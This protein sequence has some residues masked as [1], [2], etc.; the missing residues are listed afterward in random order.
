MD[1][2]TLPELLNS[3]WEDYVDTNLPAQHIFNLFQSREGKI[4]NDHVAFRTYNHPKV[5]VDMLGKLFTD[6]GYQEKDDYYFEKKNT[7]KVIA[8]ATSPV[9][10]GKTD[11]YS[12]G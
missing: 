10:T 4:I 12:S 3:L 6:L 8:T 9:Q 11:M 2:Y 1:N 5:N 7:N